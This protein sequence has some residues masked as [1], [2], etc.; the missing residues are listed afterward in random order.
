VGDTALLLF[1]TPS[2]CVMKD[3]GDEFSDVI[4]GDNVIVSGDRKTVKRVTGYNGGLV[5]SRIPLRPGRLFQVYN[6][7]K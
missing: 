2:N 4:R 1:K 7:N 3:G 5:I 6:I